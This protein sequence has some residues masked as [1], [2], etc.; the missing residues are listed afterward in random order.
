M[1]LEATDAL[2]VTSQAAVTSVNDRTIF[3]LRL[4]G[5]RVHSHFFLLSR[6]YV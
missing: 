2:I 6:C 3:K 4:V 1:M 5:F